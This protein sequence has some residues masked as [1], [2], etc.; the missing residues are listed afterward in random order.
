MIWTCTKDW[1]HRK[2]EMSVWVSLQTKH[3][4]IRFRTKEPDYQYLPEQEFDWSR[5]VYGKV[6]EEFG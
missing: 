2:D 1:A 6:A 3:Y 4:A 5:T